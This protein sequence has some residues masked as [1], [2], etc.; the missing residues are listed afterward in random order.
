MI[1]T[2]VY[3]FVFFSASI[4]FCQEQTIGFYGKKISIGMT[5]EEIREL[6]SNDYK[7]TEGND[8]YWVLQDK[9][10]EDPLMAINFDNHGVSY[11]DRDW[12][13][14]SNDQET[15]D[16]TKKLFLLLKH[17]QKEGLNLAS[18]K[19]SS[20]TQEDPWNRGNLLNVYKITISYGQKEVTL[21]IMDSEEFNMSLLSEEINK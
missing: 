3:L 6:L 14:Q 12:A 8:E 2:Y 5:H 17:I 19:T 18:V 9:I 11:V 10:T 20:Y 21:E 7:L 1:K 4:L 13:E 15:F 16:F